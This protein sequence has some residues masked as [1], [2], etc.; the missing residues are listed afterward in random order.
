MTV[1]RNHLVDRGRLRRERR[2]LQDIL[3]MVVW[4]LATPD[5]FRSVA[6]RFGVNPGTLYYFYSYIIEALRELSATFITWPN[7][8][9]R[10]V[11]SATFQRATGFPGVIGCI[12]CTHIE[13]TAPLVD[14]AQYIN[15]HHSYSMNVQAVVDSSLLVRDLHVGEVGSMN[16]ARVFRRSPLHRDLL[17]DLNQG[18]IIA[19]EEHIVG[20]GAYTVTDFVSKF[21]FVIHAFLIPLSD[22]NTSLSLFQMMTPFPRH[23]NLTDQQRNFNRRLSQCRVRVENAFALEKG[24][25]RRTKHLN[26]RI[27]ANVVDHITAS[28]VL[29]NFII[30]HGTVALHVSCDFLCSFEFLPPSV[31]GHD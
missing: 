27:P 26:A 13:I 6:L 5:S 19:R 28:F 10:R 8:E 15:R 1:V 29:H 11:I 23:G 3:L 22:F 17:R 4:L 25:W 21:T 9:E 7:A 31:Y 18:H 20:D 2:P 30:L 12:D 14:A 24:K 16:D